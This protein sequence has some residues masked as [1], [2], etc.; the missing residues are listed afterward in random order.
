MTSS[1]TKYGMNY[2]KRGKHKNQQWCFIVEYTLYEYNNAILCKE[3]SGRNVCCICKQEI[4]NAPRSVCHH[5]HRRAEIYRA[6]NLKP[7][8]S[9]CVGMLSTQDA[10][11]WR[12]GEGEGILSCC[13]WRRPH[14]MELFVWLMKVKVKKYSS[15]PPRYEGVREE[16]RY[17]S[18]QNLK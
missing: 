8:I 7:Y 4:M 10:E 1:V 11:P 2:V 18:I 15:S 5:G 14:G 17:S 13:H 9:G 3:R 6:A 16:Q 12:I